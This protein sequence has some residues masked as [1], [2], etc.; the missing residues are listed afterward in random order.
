MIP[1]LSH[2]LCL[3]PHHIPIPIFSLPSNS[4]G[5]SKDSIEAHKMNHYVHGIEIM[6]STYDTKRKIVD[7][8]PDPLI[9][10]DQKGK[11]NLKKKYTEKKGQENA[12]L[13][14]K[15]QSS[16]SVLGDSKIIAVRAGS[17]TIDDG[18]KK[19]HNEKIKENSDENNLDK[20]SQKINGKKNKRNTNKVLSRNKKPKLR[21]K[22]P[23][24]IP[25]LGMY[26]KMN[27]RLDSALNLN[28]LSAEKYDKLSGISHNDSN[29]NDFQ[30]LFYSFSS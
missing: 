22:I 5:F 16:R 27:M 19:N 26:F 4:S 1:S 8:N 2:S 7:R 29:L 3:S 17:I 11:G 20:N 14:S 21:D 13:N 12:N 28:L 24:T 15:H 6:A 23:S 18:K 25:G 10:H 9:K 30:D